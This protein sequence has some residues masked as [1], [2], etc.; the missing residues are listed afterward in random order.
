MHV[1]ADVFTLYGFKVV[2]RLK[3]TRLEANIHCLLTSVGV[4]MGCYSTSES[5]QLPNAVDLFGAHP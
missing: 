5:V 4:G 1:T 2:T 3:L